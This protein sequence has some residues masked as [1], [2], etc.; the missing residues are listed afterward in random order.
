MPADIW[1]IYMSLNL[2]Y[3]TYVWPLLWLRSKCKFVSH[4]L[5]NGIN[6]TKYYYFPFPQYKR[7][8]Y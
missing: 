2:R 8:Y 3:V 4:K 6:A 7:D 5:Y 1:D